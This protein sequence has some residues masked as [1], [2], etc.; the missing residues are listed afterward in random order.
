MHLNKYI[1]LKI[2]SFTRTFAYTDCYRNDVSG[3]DKMRQH[4]AAEQN[5]VVLAENHLEWAHAVSR[6]QVRTSKYR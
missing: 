2:F 6:F 3:A 5:V 4:F 1:E